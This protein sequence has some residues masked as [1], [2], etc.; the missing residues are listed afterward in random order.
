MNKKVRR[1]KYNN[2]KPVFI[3]EF[4]KLFVVIVLVVM[5]VVTGFL[6]REC[7]NIH[8]ETNQMFN[9]QCAN[10]RELLERIY[11]S[12]DW[13]ITRPVQYTENGYS[14]DY[15]IYVSGILDSSEN[16]NDELERDFS[17]AIL[18]DYASNMFGYKIGEPYKEW[19]YTDT[20]TK[21][22][23]YD[24]S[25]KSS[26]KDTYSLVS[27]STD[28][29]YIFEKYYYQLDTKNGET[30]SIGGI[31]VNHV[32][33]ADSKDYLDM[34]EK[35][36]QYSNVDMENGKDEYAYVIINEAYVN[37]D[38]G[39]LIIKD[40]S[41]CIDS[42]E[43]AEK[44]NEPL[45]I[46]NYSYNYEIP[47]GYEKLIMKVS[48]DEY[49]AFFYGP[50]MPT[51]SGGIAETSLEAFISENID[52]WES[53]A[54]MGTDKSDLF[55]VNYSNIDQFYYISEEYGVS[56]KYYICTSI[57]RDL[58][59]EYAT[60]VI[61][62]YIIAIIISMVCAFIISIIRYQRLNAD[63]EMLVYRKT[64]MDCLAHD[65]KSPLMAISGYAENLKE[66]V[67]TE[68]KD[69]YSEKI[70]DTVDYMN[71]IISDTLELSK[72][73]ENAK[74]PE[75]KLIEM[76]ELLE[77]V[78]KQYEERFEE[79]SL[80]VDVTGSWQIK[81]DRAMMLRVCDNL[82]GNISKYAKSDSAVD[83]TLDKGI[84][85]SNSFYKEACDVKADELLKPFVKGSK[86]RSNEQGAGMGL[87]IVKELL[88]VQGY[89][90]ELKIEDEQFVVTIK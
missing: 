75:L 89:T 84:K 28:K 37:G 2:K 71:N 64:L 52:E 76:R 22:Y 46:I 57:Y 24:E 86:S 29:I 31:K 43:N 4:V 54:T 68:K 55:H 40:A 83:I 20:A 90:I 38:T 14:P 59:D 60:T 17:V 49:S 67:H 16:R 8:N 1:K 53:Y 78:L 5:L 35:Y 45:N 66:N 26:E 25:K 44:G 19:D 85:I 41:L 81:A 23:R 21:I 42:N 69:E 72:L 34:V 27:N 15:D 13:R 51:K 65:L 12:G 32:F 7:Q 82:M 30:G 63:Y 39:K 33:E 61:I 79:K 88:E 58:V 36:Q 70:M 10:K 6:Y 9:L 11:E 47:E 77:E 62:I 87:A 3:L 73:E 74:K 50:V 80:Q 18:S 48:D 56:P